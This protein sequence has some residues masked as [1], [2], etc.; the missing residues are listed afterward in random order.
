MKM[1]RIWKASVAFLSQDLLPHLIRR[2]AAKWFVSFFFLFE[3]APVVGFG[4]NDELME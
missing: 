3:V 2:P 4:S 1:D